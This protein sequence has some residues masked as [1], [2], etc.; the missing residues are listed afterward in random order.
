MKSLRYLCCLSCELY[1]FVVNLIEAAPQAK[2]KK[3]KTIKQAIQDKEDKAK[4]RALKK[5]EENKSAQEVKKYC[6]AFVAI[7]MAPL[8]DVFD[9]AHCS[10]RKN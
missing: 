8:S 7:I 4:E 6:S 3:R 2:V 9:F 10:H 1:N 5:Q